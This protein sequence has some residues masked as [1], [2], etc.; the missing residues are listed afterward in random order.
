[1]TDEEF[2][3]QKV[4]LFM[5]ADKKVNLGSGLLRVM[6]LKL[7]LNSKLGFIYQRHQLK[8]FFVQE[9]ENNNIF[10]IH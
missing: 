5:R 1:M 9:L 6:V 4:R 8:S 7:I 2:L 3:E 10:L